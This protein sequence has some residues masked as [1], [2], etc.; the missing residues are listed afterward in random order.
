[1]DGTNSTPIVT[2][3]DQ[4]SGITIDCQHSRLYWASFSY[5]G[6]FHTSDKQ[7]QDIKTVVQLPSGSAPRGIGLLARRVYLT[8]PESIPESSVHF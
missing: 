2:G 1:M 5:D 3:L 4:A 6:K 7:R 8:K